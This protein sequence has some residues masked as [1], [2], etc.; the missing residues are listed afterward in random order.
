VFVEFLFIYFHQLQKG[1]SHPHLVFLLLVF[2]EGMQVDGLGASEEVHWL[3]LVSVLQVV[4][5]TA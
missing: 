1:F 5:E 4:K 3:Q 2:V